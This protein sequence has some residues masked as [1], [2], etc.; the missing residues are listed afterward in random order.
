MPNSIEIKQMK[1]KQGIGTR[2]P[3]EIYTFYIKNENM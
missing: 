3:I 2:L 1:S